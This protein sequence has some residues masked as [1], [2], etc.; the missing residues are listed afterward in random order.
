MRLAFCDDQAFFVDKISAEVNFYFL[1]RNITCVYDKFVSAS[2][3]LLA[4]KTNTYDAIFLDVD[5]PEQNGIDTAAEIQKL[6]PKCIFIF[7]SA[8]IEYATEGYYVNALRYILKSQTETVLPNCLE[9]LLEKVDSQEDIIKVYINGEDTQRKLSDIL[10]FEGAQHYVIIHP[11]DLKA[12]KELVSVKLTELE[13]RLESKGFLRIHKSL[14]V[15]MRYITLIRNYT[16]TLSNAE[17]LKVSETNYATIRGK[18][19]LWKGDNI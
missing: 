9:T 14:L 18:Y 5:M 19:L 10:Y 6:L 11:S 16:A 17:Q 2:K 4:C 7:I 15:N 8:H 1:K 12:P 13:C 3:L